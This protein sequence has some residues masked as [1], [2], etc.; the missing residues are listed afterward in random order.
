MPWY[1]KLQGVLEPAQWLV[2][3]GL[4][5]IGAISWYMIIQKNVVLRTMWFV[6]LISP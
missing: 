5:V 1:K 2:I 6:Y 4:L 3:G